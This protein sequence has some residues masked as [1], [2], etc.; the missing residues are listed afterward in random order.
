VTPKRVRLIDT[1]GLKDDAL[2]NIRERIS[3]LGFR[4]AF[5]NGKPVESTIT[6]NYLF[7]KPIHSDEAPPQS[8]I[9]QAGKT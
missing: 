8:L 6:V 5:V 3:L 1:S 7:R 4:P 9:N 2:Q